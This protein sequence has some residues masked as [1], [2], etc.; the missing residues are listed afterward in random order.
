M[1]DKDHGG[2]ACSKSRRRCPG[3]PHQC[4]G[5]DHGACNDGVC[6]CRPEWR[7]DACDEST[8]PRPCPRNCSSHGECDTLTG[9]CECG[10][11]WTG[12]ACER[13][14]GTLSWAVFLGFVSGTLLGATLLAGAATFAYC[15]KVRGVRREDVMRFRFDVRKEEGWRATEAEGQIPG[16]RF[17]RFFGDLR[18]EDAGSGAGGLGANVI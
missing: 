18:D 4:S 10:D 17:E 2:T 13:P 16:A 8:D 14:A 15:V 1:C 11:E 9:V 5:I 6:S 7:G 3:F 12:G